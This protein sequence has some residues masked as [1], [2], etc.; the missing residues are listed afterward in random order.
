MS[1]V[2]TNRNTF[3]FR[4]VNAEKL[5]G[6]LGLVP[7]CEPWYDDLG[8]AQAGFRLEVGGE[9]VIWTRPE[10][11]VDPLNLLAVL[12]AHDPEVP[13]PEPTADVELAQ[14]ILNASGDVTAIVAALE[15]WADRITG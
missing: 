14:A 10:A 11:N 7:G 5:A 9:I 1:D 8:N 6:E 2:L 12:N 4:E 15:A 3:S 13:E